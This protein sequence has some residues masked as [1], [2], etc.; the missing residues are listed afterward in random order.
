MAISL[1]RTSMPLAVEQMAEAAFGAS[2]QVKLNQLLKV[3]GITGRRDSLTEIQQ[4]ILSAALSL[5][6]APKSPA[7]RTAYTG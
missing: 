4:K 6:P 1:K 7:R 2:G 3:A 5:I